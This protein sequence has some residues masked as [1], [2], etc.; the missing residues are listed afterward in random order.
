LIHGFAN[1][2]FVPA[3]EKA[4]GEIGEMFRQQIRDR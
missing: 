2:A 4:V 3:A 1:M